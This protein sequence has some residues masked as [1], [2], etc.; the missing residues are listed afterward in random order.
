MTAALPRAFRWFWA[1]ETVSGFGSWIT[2]IALQ[3]IV[4]DHLH[5]GTVGLGWLNAARWL[6]YLLFGLVLGALIDRVRRRPVM[7]GTDLVRALLLCAIPALWFT[8]L[9][10]LSALI[11]L[12]ALLGTATL[13]NDSASQAFLPRLVVRSSLQSAHARIDGTN[14]AAETA[15]PAIG[16]ALLALISAPLAVLINVSTFL[17]S[18]IVVALIRVEEPKLPQ[19]GAATATPSDSSPMQPLQQPP[20]SKQR[21]DTRSWPD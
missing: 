2:M 13:V 12:V 3:V 1:G 11:L 5:A 18:A 4:V 7:I 8:D 21:L 6:P 19:A 16:G 9:L 14:A 17:F 20:P 15:G 10:D